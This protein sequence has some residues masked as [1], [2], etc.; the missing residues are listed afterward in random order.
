MPRRYFKFN[1][2]KFKFQNDLGLSENFL[3]FIL[4]Y[5]DE[6]LSALGQLEQDPD[7]SEM[8]QQLLDEGLL[9]KIKGRWRLT[10]RAVNAMQRKAL[11]EIFA[12]MSKGTREGHASPDAGAGGERIEGT[13]PYQFGDPVSELDVSA[14]RVLRA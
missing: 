14:T 2:R 10:P 8:L 3:D 4:S 12:Q 5:G 13:R 9:E 6:A 7:Q 11:M 1:G